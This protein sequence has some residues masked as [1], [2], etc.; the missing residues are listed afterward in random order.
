MVRF[1]DWRTTAWLGILAVAFPFGFVMSCCLVL[2]RFGASGPDVFAPAFFSP[3][4]SL[5][6]LRAVAAEL[7]WGRQRR[8]WRNACRESPRSSGCGS[9]VLCIASQFEACRI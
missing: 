5:A 4:S 8:I 6:Q 9:G 2:I 1:Y 7:D 3:A